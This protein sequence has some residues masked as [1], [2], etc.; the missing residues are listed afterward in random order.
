MRLQDFNIKVRLFDGQDWQLEASSSPQSSPQDL[1][2]IC[3]V[4]HQVRLARPPRPSMELL[5][6]QLRI[7]FSSLLPEHEET[8]RLVVAANDIEILDHVPTSTWRKFLAPM[9]SST[10]QLPRESQSEMLRIELTQIRPFPTS[11][12]REYRLKFSLLPIRLFVD[13][14]ALNFLIDFFLG[15]A[16]QD[17]LEPPE[18]THPST[19]DDV[20]FR[21]L[22]CLLG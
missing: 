15:D 17:P 5:V 7:D 9:K 10:G 13:Q 11:P 3:R 12:S 4:H 1:P 21:K 2:A 6:S 8:F 16:Q 22:F 18:P 14:D 19:G 20:F